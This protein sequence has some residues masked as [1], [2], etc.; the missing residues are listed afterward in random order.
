MTR[1]GETRA[2]VLRGSRDLSEETLHAHAL[3]PDGGW[4]RVEACGMCGSDWN[5]YANREVAVPVVL[6]HEIVGTVTDLWG[7]MAD[8]PGIGVGDRVVLEEAVPCRTCGLCRTGRHRLCPTAGRY[9][10]R[11]LDVAP[12]LWGGYSEWVFID[13]RAGLHSVP[14]GLDSS[15]AALFIPLSNGISWLAIAARMRPGDSV[16]VLGPGQHGLACVVAARRL[17]AGAVI[18]AGRSGDEGRLKAASALGAD[19]TVDIDEEPLLQAIL[20]RTDGA[21]VD[22][23]VDA[24]P[25]ATSALSAA[26]AGAAVGGRIV[27]AGIKNHAPSEVDTDVILRR[28]LTVRGVAAR[29]SWAIDVA[30]RWLAQSP[31]TFA[32]FGGMTVGLSDVETALL[33]L[34]GEYGASRPLHAVVVPGRTVGGGL[35]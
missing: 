31:E 23:V 1:T 28:E 27:V 34:G 8:R 6:G 18:V 7:S 12:G 24:T 11:G 22:V 10:G 16:V 33:A 30:L 15:L 19:V 14:E 3:P 5:A 26:V 9:G 29:E 4:L 2:V 17:G 25:G 32:P 13:P 35:K 20:D 21:G